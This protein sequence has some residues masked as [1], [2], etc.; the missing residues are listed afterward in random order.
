MCRARVTVVEGSRGLEEMLRKYELF[1]VVW[2]GQQLGTSSEACFGGVDRSIG[3]FPMAMCPAQNPTET[4]RKVGTALLLAAFTAIGV[5]IT[6]LGFV[7][8]F[9]G[10]VLG[11]ALVFIY[12]TMMW[13]KKCRQDVRS[14][15]PP[16]VSRAGLIRS[17]TLGKPSQS[18]PSCPAPLC[19]SLYGIV[20]PQISLGFKKEHFQ[21]NFQRVFC[22]WW[23]SCG[24]R[25]VMGGGSVR[26]EP[27]VENGKKEEDSRFASD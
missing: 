4:Q 5:T 8:S 21:E 3:R 27:G 13:I 10:A 16:K 20:D 9:G 1:V 2:G 22:V 25:W 26:E 7:V 17:S 24:G 19:Q 23:M 15:K 6:D 14:G 18:E 11:S 12:P